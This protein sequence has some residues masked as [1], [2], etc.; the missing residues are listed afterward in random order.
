[1]ARHYANE[2]LCVKMATEGTEAYWNGR[3]TKEAITVP[4]NDLTVLRGFGVFDFLRT[5][6]RFV[7]QIK[8]IRLLLLMFMGGSQPYRNKEHV[9]RLFRSA[10]LLGLTVPV[11]QDEVISGPKLCGFCARHLYPPPQLNQRFFRQ[12]LA[13]V[14]EGIRR[15][16]HLSELYIKLT[17]T[18]TV[19]GLLARGLTTMLTSACACRRY[20]QRRKGA[21]AW[22]VVVLHHVRPRVRHPGILLPTG[23]GSFFYY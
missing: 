13:L 9:E 19:L 3:W 11:T 4:A 20:G 2:F 1:L 21:G 7:H 10:E 23:K 15:N 16:P 8:Y 14:E 12:A 22:R 6:N 17:V 5:Y 18:G